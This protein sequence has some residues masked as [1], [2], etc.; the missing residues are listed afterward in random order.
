MSAINSYKDRTIRRKSAAGRWRLAGLVVAVLALATAL[1]S[2]QPAA[3][4]QALDGS[5]FNPGYIIDDSNFYNANAMSQ[6]QIQAFLQAEEPGTC[7]NALCLKNYRV[8]T[9]TNNSIVVAKDGTVLCTPYVGAANE[10]ASQIIFKAQQ[11]CGIS[12]KVLL[13]TLQK[14]Q[15]L[16]TS[17]GP[18]TAALQR[19]MGYACPDTAPCAPA[20]LGFAN[21]LYVGA[22]QLL[23]YRHSSTFKQPGA[24]AVRYSPNAVCGTKTVNVVNYAT[25]ALYNYTPYTPDAAALANLFGTGDNCSSYGNRNFWV[26]Y[27]QWFG[28]PTGNPQG[29]VQAISTGNNTVTV[30]GWAVDPDAATSPI[31]VQVRGTGWSQT[32]SAGGSNPASQAVFA[33]GG[34][35]HGFAATVLAASGSQS[36][37]VDAVNVGLGTSVTLGCTTVT[38][39]TTL[40]STRINGVDRFATAV[41]VSSQT[42][43]GVQTVYVASGENFPDALSVAPVAAKAGV[44]L[45]LVT[46]TSVPAN[47]SAELTRLHP[48]SIVVV[49]GV[50]AISDAVLAQLN[51][52]APATRLSG[53]D[54]YQTSL[55]V[56][57]LLVARQ[58]SHHV[59]LATA[60]NFPDALSSASSAGFMSSPLVL[61]DGTASTVPADLASDLQAWGITQ[62]TVVGGT[63]V[64]TPQ[65]VAAVGAVPGVTSVTRLAGVDRYSTSVAVNSATF[66]TMTGAFVANGTAFPDGLTGGALAGKMGMPM[67]LVP[68]TCIPD[69]ALQS[70][71]THAPIIVRIVGGTSAVTPAVQTFAP[72]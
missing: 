18:S 66:P 38:V 19:A 55:A 63:S 26:Y 21:Q 51:A 42:A 53:V 5:Q 40:T 34:T 57:A 4:A 59:Y 43:P 48:A 10:P 37:C 14:E 33:G 13:V 32:I 28:G 62:V 41:A 16:V 72:C 64:M 45:L 17:M 70:M 23:R 56:G 67:Y 11:A 47:V 44:P 2:I 22:S 71:V 61:V 54:R 15:S 50:D 12:A 6:A 9:T 39:P 20:T 46:S 49:G 65:F 27:N 29:A 69:A 36:I 3:S 35:N 68:G 24:W 30:S 58:H 8:T 31:N 7:G 60:A 25:A 1:V 52:I